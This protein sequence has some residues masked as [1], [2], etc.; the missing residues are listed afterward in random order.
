MTEAPRAWR[1]V[2]PHLGYDLPVDLTPEQ[3]AGPV[4]ATLPL[5]LI[6]QSVS[7]REFWPVPEPVAERY[8][9]FRP[10][11]L[12]RARRFEAEIQAAVPIYVK[13][14]G[15]NI[16]GSHK[17]NTALAQAYYYHRAGFR[18]LVTG[19]GAGQWGSALA[20]ACAAFGLACTV[21]MVG[22]S[23]RD[24]PYRGSLIRLYG[25]DLHTSP[26]QLTALGRDATGNHQQGN[27]LALAIGEAVEYAR[28][29]PKRAFCIGSGETYSILH[30]SVIGLEAIDQLAALG[31]EVDTVVGCVGAGSNFG[32]V[33]LP[34]FAAARAGELPRPAT[35]VAAESSTTPKLTRGVYAYD[36]TDST[37]TGPMEAM[38]TIGSRYAIPPSHAAGLRFHGAAKLISAMRH[39]DQISALAI[40]QREALSA[41]RV[42]ATSELV[43]PAPESG[44]ALAAAARVAAGQEPDLASRHGVLVC[45]S[46]HGLLDLAAYDKLLA[47]LPE[48]Q[49]ADPEA[50]REA[51]ATLRPVHP[52]EGA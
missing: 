43:L 15:G 23:L 26:S 16:S 1:S 11:P 20:A 10:A 51:T 40:G 19:T 14:E 3:G 30:Q 41:G 35:L 45:V 38:Y 6:R 12:W 17:F 34:F 49:P 5:E 22:G 18:E 33:A 9:A 2:L 28:T 29:D 13:Y 4:T 50:L 25:A 46:G 47:G 36:H 27:S 24:K 7:Q 32:G 42:F 52:I 44:H 39:R 31:A 37:G 48:D 21:F 8:R